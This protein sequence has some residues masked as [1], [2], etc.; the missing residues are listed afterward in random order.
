VSREEA[1]RRELTEAHAAY[2]VA[3]DRYEKA[4]AAVVWW[5][6]E[7]VEQGGDGMRV[8]LL[9]RDDLDKLGRDEHY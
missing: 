7:T 8:T 1:I 4:Q 9:S 2:W 6:I 3:K 5:A